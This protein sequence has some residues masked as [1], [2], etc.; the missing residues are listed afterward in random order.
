MLEEVRDANRKLLISNVEKIA[1]LAVASGLLD[2]E[3][4]TQNALPG[5]L[6]RAGLWS[7]GMKPTLDLGQLGLDENDLQERREKEEKDRLE[8]QKQ[9][10]PVTFGTTDVDGGLEGRFQLVAQ[11]L[12]AAFESKEFQKRSGEA[13]LP[14]LASGVGGGGGNQRGRKRTKD[15]EYSSEQQRALLGFAGELAAYRHLK[16]T[17]RTLA[18]QGTG[19][20]ENDRS[21]TTNRDYPMETNVYSQEQRRARQSTGVRP[22]S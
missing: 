9:K 22:H 18:I 3:V 21:Q 2:F 11:A 20:R 12:D 15:P 16:K 5:V 13:N 4:L 1:R 14:P 17:L 6:S 8:I 10:R 19:T 7:T